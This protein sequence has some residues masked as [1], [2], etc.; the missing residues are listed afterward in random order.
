MSSR[1][2]VKAALCCGLGMC[3]HLWPAQS[4]R[5]HMECASLVTTN[6]GCSGERGGVQVAHGC[7]AAENMLGNRSALCALTR[8]RG[9]E[10]LE[11]DIDRRCFA[12]YC[13]LS[14]SL[15]LELG[16]LLFALLHR[17]A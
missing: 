5:H 13:L 11:R 6:V 7:R 4:Y 17:L 10:L 16:E 14:A 3:T 1:E 12:Y 8:G 15:S 2:K 9:V